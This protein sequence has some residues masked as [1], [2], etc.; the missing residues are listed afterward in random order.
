MQI[1]TDF[2]TPFSNKNF[3]HLIKHLGI[4]QK[5]LKSIFSNLPEN[6]VDVIRK[7]FLNGT[8]SE[9]TQVKHLTGIESMNDLEKS[10][11]REDLLKN[12]ESFFQKNENN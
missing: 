4:S 12:A 8:S 5:E 10:F 1:I 11:D 3:E 7:A 6:I 9:V 2:Y